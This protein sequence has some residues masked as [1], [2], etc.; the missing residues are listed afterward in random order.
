MSRTHSPLATKYYSLKKELA[1]ELK[2]D[3]RDREKIVILE[4]EI[5]KIE[6]QIKPQN[7]LSTK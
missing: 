2:K 3:K 6:P 5:A 4:T 1:K 7:N